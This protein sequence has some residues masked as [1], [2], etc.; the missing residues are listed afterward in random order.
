MF[1]AISPNSDGFAYFPHKC[2]GFLE[3]TLPDARGQQIVLA[4]LM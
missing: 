3:L 1:F 4:D 2:G